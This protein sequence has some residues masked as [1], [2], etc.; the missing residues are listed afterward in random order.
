MFM[1]H[2]Q[3]SLILATGGTAMVRAA[4]SSGTPAIGVGSGNVPALVCADADPVAAAGAVV[5]SKAF[6]HGM[7]CGSE[8]HLVVEGGVRGPFVA[9]LE[10]AGAAVARGGDGQGGRRG[11]RPRRAPAARGPRPAGR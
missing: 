10:A 5:E 1:R 7:I 2:P 3:V 8:H 4:Y 9:A 11:L 6:D